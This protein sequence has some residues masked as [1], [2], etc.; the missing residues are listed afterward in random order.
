MYLVKDFLFLVLVMVYRSSQGKVENLSQSVHSKPQIVLSSLLLVKVGSVQ[1]S[2]RS[3]NPLCINT[4]LFILDEFSV[5][6]Y[7]FG[8]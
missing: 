4:L 3:E 2:E 6:M 7:Q 8:I 1:I 5:L